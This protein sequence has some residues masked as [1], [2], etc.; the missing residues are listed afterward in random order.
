MTFIFIN[1]S[2]ET[3]T[4]YSGNLLIVKTNDYEKDALDVL[5][6]ALNVFI[7]FAR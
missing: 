2:S 7:P 5:K 1:R 6:H 3:L 4:I